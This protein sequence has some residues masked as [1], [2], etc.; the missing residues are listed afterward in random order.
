MP[1][2]MSRL[3]ALLCIDLASVGVDRGDV[4]YEVHGVDFF[5]VDADFEVE[6][7]AFGVAGV[8][9]VADE[10]AGGNDVAGFE[11]VPNT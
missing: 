1:Q 8:A 3:R 2:M 7:R 11:G 6:V 5:A 9:A 4:T 10:L